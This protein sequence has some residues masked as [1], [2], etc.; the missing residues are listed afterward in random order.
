LIILPLLQAN[1]QDVDRTVEI[2]K[3]KS[4]VLYCHGGFAIATSH[5]KLQPGESKTV[6]CDTNRPADIHLKA[7]IQH[8]EDSEKVFWCDHNNPLIIAGASRIGYDK[9][10]KVECQ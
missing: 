5:V 10:F 9:V 2:K 3:E 1:A 8:G 7:G 4:Y 6:G